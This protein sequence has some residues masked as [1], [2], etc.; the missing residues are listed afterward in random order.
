MQLFLQMFQNIL[1]ILIFFV[2][3]GRSTYH[4]VGK[5]GLALPFIFKEKKEIGKI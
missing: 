5:V 3:G 4:Q 1:S 2:G